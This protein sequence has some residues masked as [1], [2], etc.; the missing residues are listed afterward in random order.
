ML[1]GDVFGVWWIVRRNKERGRTDKEGCVSR[2][3]ECKVE[4]SFQRGGII[5]GVMGLPACRLHFP[6]SK[7]IAI[8]QR[9][10]LKGV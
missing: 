1:G 3:G 8:L 4:G 7:I 6:L 2:G 10:R 9:A 5:V